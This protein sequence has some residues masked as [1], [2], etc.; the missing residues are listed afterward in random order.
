[1]DNETLSLSIQAMLIIGVVILIGAIL[2]CQAKEIKRRNKKRM[3]DYGFK[4]KIK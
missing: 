3:Q 1:M 4:H 2:Y